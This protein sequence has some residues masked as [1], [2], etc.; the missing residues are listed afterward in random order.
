MALAFESKEALNAELSRWKT[1]L[2]K[3]PDS[4]QPSG[5]VPIEAYPGMLVGGAVMIPLA[6]LAAVLVSAL[7]SVVT[8]VLA[9][10]IA[11]L[12]ALPLLFYI[13]VLI[14]GAM[15]LVAAFLGWLFTYLVLGGICGAGVSLGGRKTKNR[16]RAA[17]GAFGFLTGAV[18][19]AVY[20]LSAQWLS[21]WAGRSDLVAFFGHGFPGLGE[22]DFGFLAWV[23]ALLG[24]LAAAIA[25]A[26]IGSA[27]LKF[28][29]SCEEFMVMESL[30]PTSLDA[31]SAIASQLAAARPDGA[32]EA[33]RPLDEGP[34][35]PKVHRCPRCGKGYLELRVKFDGQ[36]QRPKDTSSTTVSEDWLC[37]S[38]PVSPAQ[39][40]ALSE[41]SEAETRDSL[42]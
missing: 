19:V 29:E 10:V 42:T 40:S 27:V 16:G 22:Y 28:C 41:K 17:A 14:V 3:V 23:N 7:A 35:E 34:L 20:F 9:Y 32:L 8:I 11:F 25:G 6:V 39:V 12:V 30:R 33:Y 15:L 2:P 13:I 37:A 38:T 31:G 1:L 5:I 4:Y 18:S 36:Y 24:I 21:N 26:V